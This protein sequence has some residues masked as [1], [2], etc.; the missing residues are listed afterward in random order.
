MS[1]V[2]P[3]VIFVNRVYWPSTAATAQLLADLAEGLAARGWPVHIIAAGTGPDQRDGVTIHRTGGDESHRGLFS[4]A[5]N[6]WRFLRGARREI[7]EGFWSPFDTLTLVIVDGFTDFL[8][9]Q[10]EILEN[11]L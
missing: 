10:Y 2:S 6:Y 9:T 5:V 1:A 7:A 11:P 8:H 3:R 4:Q